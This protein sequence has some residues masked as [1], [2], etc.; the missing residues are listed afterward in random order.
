MKCAAPDFRIMWDNA[1]AVHDFGASGD[2]LLNIFEEAKKYGNEDRILYFASTS[3][4]TF[5]GSGV[6]IV[7][8]SPKNIA[9][10]KRRMTV[11]TIGYD[12]IN[13]L[14]HV[15][16]FKNAERVKEH[17][18][19]LGELIGKKFKITLDAL[20]QLE[21]LDIAEWTN[22]VGGYF[23][24][25]DITVGSATRVFELMKNAGV[26]LTQVGATFPYGKDP[27]D[28]NLRLAPTYPADED[29]ELACRIL[30]LSVKMSA[31]ESILA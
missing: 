7:S 14:R 2:K 5:P 13:Q 24:S 15:E 19:S 4:I 26:V 31:L 18:L 20:R 29:L 1:Y 10:I 21:G 30:V 11:Q 17:M 23:I 8:A 27:D 16:Y 28:K 9:D 22:P 6:A 25:L 12:K 3:K